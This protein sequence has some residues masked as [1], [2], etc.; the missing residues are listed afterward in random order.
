[1]VIDGAKQIDNFDVKRWVNLLKVTY[2]KTLDYD[3]KGN[4]TIEKSI[5]SIWQ[6]FRRQLFAHLHL[7]WWDLT[8]EVGKQ[9]NFT[10]NREIVMMPRKAWDGGP[11][12]WERI[13]KRRE[14]RVSQWLKQG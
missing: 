10:Y 6:L 5:R 4:M 12:C 11:D 2:I 8:L 13:K 14:L 1:M 9:M 7:K 3:H